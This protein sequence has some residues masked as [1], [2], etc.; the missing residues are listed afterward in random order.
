M[1]GFIYVIT[2]PTT[3]TTQEVMKMASRTNITILDAE[4]WKWAK[5]KAID[6]DFENVSQYIFWLIKQ[7]K[8][9]A[10]KERN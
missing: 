2:P 6:M 3:Q 8:E 1:R 7:D 4:L 9:N 5:K 10:N